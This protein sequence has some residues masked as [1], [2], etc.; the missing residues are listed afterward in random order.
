VRVV[1]P[2][3]LHLDVLAAL[4]D[5]AGVAAS[6]TTDAYLAAL[7]I[8]HGLELH[9]HDRDFDRFS[10]VVRVDPLLAQRGDR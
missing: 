4:S 7:A 10:R 1:E 2:G 3:P 6:L 8:E 5:E 9:R